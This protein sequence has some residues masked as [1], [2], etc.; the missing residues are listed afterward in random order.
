[1]T[2]DDIISIVVNRLTRTDLTAIA[3]TEMSFI[4]ATQLEGAPFLP[5]FTESKN[6]TLLI[7]A[8]TE[9]VAIPADFIRELDGMGMY[10]QDPTAL[11][12][13]RLLKEDYDL[14]NENLEPSGALPLGYAIIGDLYYF[15]PVPTQG[16]VLRTFTNVRQADPSVSTGENKWM[17][18][19][20]D[21][22]IGSLGY[23]LATTYMQSPAQAAP[24][25][26]M[27][28]EAIQRLN[29]MH[30]ARTHAN[31][32]YRMGGTED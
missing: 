8:D 30:E 10:Y 12:Y 4:Q 14:L 5:W 13:T 31:R 32:D 19:A 15:R 29:I 18:W 22:F 20:P 3:L 23:L 28:K 21:L 17:K 2:R 1:M 7:T 24:F 6:D 25:D 27:R 16:L 11:T 9:T 26:G